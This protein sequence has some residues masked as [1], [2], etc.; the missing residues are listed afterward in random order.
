MANT[1]IYQDLLDSSEIDTSFVFNPELFTEKKFK[2]WVNN[3]TRLNAF[4]MNNINALI[5]AYGTW[6]GKETIDY[7]N[8]VPIKNII[9]NNA[10]WSAKLNG[11]NGEIFSDYFNNTAVGNHSSVFGENNNADNDDQFV[12]GKYNLSNPDAVFMVGW[13]T[14]NENRKN[15]FTVLQ[16]GRA[17]TEAAPT[18]PKD[19]VNKQHLDTELERVKQLNQWIGNLSVTSDQFDLANDNAKLKPLL[20]QFVESKSPSKREPRNGDLVT[21][22]ITDKKPTDPQYPEI[23]IFLE[24]DP[25]KP[26]EHVGDW[27][28]YSSQQEIL[29]ASKDVKGLVQIG[30][31]I[32]VDNGL[33]SIPVATDTVLGV[34]KNGKTIVNKSGTLDVNTGD[35]F[36]VADDGKINIKLATK[37]EAGIVS[38][39][40]NIQVDN[41]K[42]SAPLASSET[43]GL[44]KFGESIVDNGDGSFSVTKASSTDFGIVK[45]G[46]NLSL[47][48]GAI[49]VPIATN[50]IPGVVQVGQN[51]T[52]Q[53]STISVDSAS[54]EGFGVVTIGNNID[55]DNGKISIRPIM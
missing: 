46:N 19:L 23:W 6:V 16:D 55:V 20:T 49:S 40:D 15:I 44:A 43:A 10:G 45:I 52:L 37:D 1:P 42:I 48:D 41:G 53:D 12:I 29:N 4:N 24:T 3:Q 35:S 54:K 18:E 9:E 21:V 36:E 47:E 2:N 22:T 39:G 30:D 26:S 17:Q 11:G 25:T 5:Q 13:G 50:F 33:I 28:F 27:Y 8:N 31:N 51:I 14:S 34:V 38:I 7:I 32:N